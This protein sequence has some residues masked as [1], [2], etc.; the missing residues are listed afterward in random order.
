MKSRPQN[1]P[2]EESTPESSTAIGVFGV[3][4]YAVSRRTH[5]FGIRMALGADRR[6][7]LV[8]VLREGVEIAVAGVLLGVATAFAF[9]GLM[10]SLLFEVPPRDPATLSVAAAT[11]LAISCLA[12]YLPARRATRV[13]PM[14]ALRVE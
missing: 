11:L 7:V 12:C 6:Q 13:D 1:P 4:A 10:H 8:H 5:E 3:T 2:N 14:T 9:A